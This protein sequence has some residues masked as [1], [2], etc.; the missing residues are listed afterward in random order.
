M[1]LEVQK[2]QAFTKMTEILAGCF[3]ANVLFSIEQLDDND[4]INSFK[5]VANLFDDKDEIFKSLLENKEEIIIVA[6]SLHLRFVA[7]FSQYN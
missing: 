3:N 2:K 7:Q 5:V 6:W 1:K 4:L